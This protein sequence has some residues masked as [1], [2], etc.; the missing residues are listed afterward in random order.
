MLEDKIIIA[1]SILGA[2]PLNLEQ[3]LKDCEQTR[4]VEWVQ[5]DVMDG[6]FTP[7]LS[8]G[9]ATVAAIR[10][11][12]GF[13]IDIHLMVSRPM[14]LL[15]AFAKSGADLIT[16][17]FEAEDSPLECLRLIHRYGKRAGIAIKPSTPVEAIEP[18]ITE[19]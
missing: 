17:H 2:D 9:P 15:E 16:V 14:A 5:V 13:F 6:R 4:Q 18:L 11:K 10:K 3:A 8:F 7:N 12:F 1:A 19:V